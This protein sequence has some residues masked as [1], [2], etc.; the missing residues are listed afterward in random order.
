MDQQQNQ[1]QNRLLIF[2]RRMGLSQKVVARLLGHKSSN[3]LS[4]YE[5]GRVLPSL[6]S[7]FRLGIILRVPVEFLFPVLYEDLRDT[8]RH[9]EE[10]L[11]APT[12]Q[13]LL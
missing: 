7:A 10:V 4:S 5:H 8:I 1:I 3:R 13:P 11:A 2:R 12:Q 9:Q 6:V